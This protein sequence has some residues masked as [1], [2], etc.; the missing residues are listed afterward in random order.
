MSSWTDLVDGILRETGKVFGETIRFIPSS[1]ASFD[2]VAVY[3]TRYTVESF[4][5][6]STNVQTMTHRLGVR[7]K[8]FS[9][10]P[11]EGDRIILREEG[12]RVIE[13]QPDGQGGAVLIVQRERFQ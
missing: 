3:D 2:V 10:S 11:E 6:M 4:D 1:G 8:E 9:I 13:V 7:L 12:F 5:G